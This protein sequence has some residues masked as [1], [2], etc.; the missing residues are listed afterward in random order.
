MKVR[1]IVNPT[2]AAGAAG[3]KIPEL[4]RR[5]DAHGVPAEVVS[6]Q[7]HGEA[8]ALARRAASEGIDVLGVMGG[9]G[10]FNEV[11]QAC[12]T[13]NRVTAF[14]PAV[15]FIPAGT[16][17]DLKRSLGLSDDL[18]AAVQ[19]I[20]AGRKRAMDVGL[21]R[22]SPPDD[23]SPWVFLNVASVGVS[24]VVCELANRGPKWAGGKITFY[25][26]ALEATFTYRNL[27]VRVL[28]DGVPVYAGPAYLV[29][30]ANGRF[31]GGGMRVAPEADVA[32][33]DFDVV[34]LGDYSRLEAVGLSRAIYAGAHLQRRKTVVA[35]GKLV[36]IQPL[37]PAGQ[38]STR[39]VE[40]DGELPPMRLPV[41]L[42]IYP[43]VLTICA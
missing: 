31:F 18:D 19:R 30:V 33:G 23:G 29:A 37:E 20:K 2:A 42:Q 26:A 1:V 8:S 38:S 4:R 40:L 6:T 12:L 9:D 5:L 43:R 35:R 15:A 22:H 10:T 32:D 28:V 25:L 3:R 34:I 21:V 41:T 14:G 39:V 36:E 16:G 27:G 17:G 7:S 13:E 11:V 24:A